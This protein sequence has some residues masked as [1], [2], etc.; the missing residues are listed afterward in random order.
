MDTPRTHRHCSRDSS[1]R[2]RTA[3]RPRMGRHPPRSSSQ[4]DTPRTH[5]H[6]SRVRPRSTRRQSRTASRSQVRR[7]PPRSSCQMDT[8]RTRQH[9]SR[10]SSRRKRTWSRSQVRRHPPRSSS[11]MDTPRTHR[12][13]SRV[14][15]RSTRR[16]RHTCRLTKR[17]RLDTSTVSRRRPASY[18]RLQGGLSLSDTPNRRTDSRRNGWPSSIACS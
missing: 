10:D 11:Q 13:C 8:P 12:H 16:Q 5:R 3:S 15:P 9:C 6:C 17:F 4:M 18:H 1:R 7:H 14:R 2:K